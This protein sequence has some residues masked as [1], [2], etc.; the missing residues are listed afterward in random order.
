MD[1]H[2]DHGDAYF[3]RLQSYTKE[4]DGS[5]SRRPSRP[6][7]NSYSQSKRRPYSG[8]RTHSYADTLGGSE[9]T[10]PRRTKRRSRRDSLPRY[11]DESVVERD[12]D[13]PRHS[14]RRPRS[15]DVAS[16]I[17]ESVDGSEIS[18]PK[19][20][21]RRPRRDDAVSI[22]PE[23]VHPS[24][25]T[26]QKKSK[27]RP[28]LD[29]L[30]SLHPE[31]P[32]ARSESYACTRPS[33][34]LSSRP[35]SYADTD[36]LTHDFNEKS[37]YFDDSPRRINAELLRRYDDLQEGPRKPWLTR[38]KKIWIGIILA[39]IALIIIIVGAVVGTRKSFKYAPSDAQVNNTIAFQ[40]G[41]AT[42]NSVNNTSDGIGAGQDVY[43]YYE[44]GPNN[45][46]DASKWISFQ[47]M[48]NNNL[49]N[50]QKSCGW[51]GYPPDNTAEQN[52]YLFNAIQDRANASLV[53][54]RYVLAIVLQESHG[55]VHVGSTES[56]GGVTNPGL[57]QSHN[58]D[59]YVKSAPWLS[60]L[61]MIQDG[62]QG[63]EDG[64][65]LVQ[66]LNAY[67]DPYSAARGYNSGH[68]AKD[69]NLSDA[70]GATACYVSDV[71]NRL[72]GW[73]NADS[74]CPGSSHN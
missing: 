64:W 71:A 18:P 34:Y 70:A 48:W 53:D 8:A 35:R 27:R 62:V 56:Y 1:Y 15:D 60:I 14:K 44:G 54:H 55:C 26:P 23:V 28:R 51:L 65:G 16:T 49:P 4:R 21:K 47:D 24:E 61:L 52:A 46:P 30:S 25:I 19:R 17:P 2:R 38:R 42:H 9:V 58:G 20:A 11:D 41:G 6:R 57:M 40:K 50:I 33:S 5:R 66:L 36:A 10:P 3:Q 32:G 74:T 68:I 31:S 39:V 7:T 12:R 29:S 45:F 73:V 22:D 69:G 13:P 59:H 37:D 72:T 63:T 43:H 67:G